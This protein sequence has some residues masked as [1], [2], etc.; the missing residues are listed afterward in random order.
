MDAGRERVVIAGR[1]EL[2]NCIGSGGTA[3]VHRALDLA[4]GR[5]VA[6]KVLRQALCDDE[7]AASRFLHEACS[8]KRLRHRNIVRTFG[9]GV[10]NGVHYIAMEYVS[11]RLLSSIVAT[12]APLEPR[13]AMEIVLQV[14]EAARFIHAHDIVHR[15]LKSA[16]V[17]VDPTGHIK[18]SD[19][20][21]ARSRGRRITSAGTLVGTIEY[22]S[23]ERVLGEAATEASDIYSIGVM[24]YELVTG[25]LPFEGDLVS[26][27]ALKH[28]HECPAP[29]RTVNAAI[30]ASLS[31]TVMRALEKA[32]RA[33]FPDAGAFIDALQHELVRGAERLPLAAT[34]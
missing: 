2:L 27:L 9:H 31:A 17:I 19:F 29:P 30:S 15:D 7:L 11:G 20:G 14:L 3:T 8:A 26:T 32:P 23:P 16:N 18:V 4:Q 22:L 21:I 24:L 10:S 33:R 5:E 12:E 25:R 13:R 34:A 28:V 6:V 1:Y